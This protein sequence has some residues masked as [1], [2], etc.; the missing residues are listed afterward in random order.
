MALSELSSFASTGTKKGFM[1]L[2]AF[3]EAK[4]DSS[5]QTNKISKLVPYPLAG[6]L[7][8]MSW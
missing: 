4:T 2:F 5:D 6:T 3:F 7:L 8:E 1:M